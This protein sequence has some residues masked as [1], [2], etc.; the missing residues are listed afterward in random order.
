MSSL[1]I[2]HRSLFFGR[3]GAGGAAAPLR[4]SLRSVLRTAALPR[5]PSS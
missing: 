3:C 1:F 4:G 2:V 5:P